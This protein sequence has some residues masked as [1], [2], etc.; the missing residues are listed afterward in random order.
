MTIVQLQF[1]GPLMELVEQ[2]QNFIILLRKLQL[3]TLMVISA[4]QGHCI[5]TLIQAKILI[6]QLP[7][8]YHGLV[9]E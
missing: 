1:Q 9:R 8:Q 7:A 4:Q 5:L 2:R 6:S 3:P